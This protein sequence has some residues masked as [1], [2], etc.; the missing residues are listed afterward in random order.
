M[1]ILNDEEWKMLED[2]K[3][4]RQMVYLMEI[5]FSLLVMFRSHS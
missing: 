1:D 4:Q 2:L 3:L 5:D